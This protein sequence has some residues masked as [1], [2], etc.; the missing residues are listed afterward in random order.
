MNSPSTHSN[1]EQRNL[2]HLGRS[3]SQ[4]TQLDLST[5]L[6]CWHAQSSWP[7]WVMGSQNW[8]ILKQCP[9]LIEV[10]LWEMRSICNLSISLAR[11]WTRDLGAL[12]AWP[13]V[14]GVVGTSPRHP[15]HGVHEMAWLQLR[16]TALGQSNLFSVCY[17]VHSNDSKAIL[18]KQSCNVRKQSNSIMCT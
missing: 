15:G 11:T 5:H 16:G 1:W 18:A 2:T 7:N 3:M 10:K 9:H 8:V 17:Y 6:T 4:V 13:R 14:V 12:W